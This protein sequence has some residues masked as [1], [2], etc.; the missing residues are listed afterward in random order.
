MLHI[1]SSE[2]SIVQFSTMIRHLF[3][4]TLFVQKF[5][6]KN[7]MSLHTLPTHQILCHL[8]SFPKFEMALNGRKFNDIIMIQAKLQN[9]LVGF[10]TAHFTQCFEQWHHSWAHHIKSQGN[11]SECDNIDWKVTWCFYG[12]INSVHRTIRSHYILKEPPAPTEQKARWG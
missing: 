6:A 4:H 7:K 10:Q 8:T 1:W 9:T 2:S 11:Y 3:I 12:E 5:L